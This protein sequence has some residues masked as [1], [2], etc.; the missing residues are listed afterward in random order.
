MKNYHLLFG[1]LLLL[2]GVVLVAASLEEVPSQRG[3]THPDFSTMQLGGDSA[4]RHGQVLWLGWSFGALVIAFFVGLI[5]AS[6]A[7]S[8]QPGKPSARRTV[9]LAGAVFELIFL[10]L[11]L[12]YR[13]FMD[14]PSMPSVLGFP[15][16]TAWMLYGIWGFPMVFV[17][18]YI[19]RFEQWVLD[20][21]AEAEF[22]KLERRRDLERAG[23]AEASVIRGG[24]QA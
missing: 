15:R 18:L 23:T 16:P 2:C 6:L 12:S 3:L 13:S 11:V 17:L 24:N 7:R 4:A 22:A 14:D 5:D 9:W 19:F 21:K 10:L 20:T 8:G 1:L